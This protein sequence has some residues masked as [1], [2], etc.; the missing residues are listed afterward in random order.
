MERTLDLESGILIFIWPLPL[1]SHSMF[2]FYH[3]KG[4]HPSLP[5]WIYLYFG[6]QVKIVSKCF[7]KHKPLQNAKDFF[8]SSAEFK[9]LFINFYGYMIINPLPHL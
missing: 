1:T 6:Y 4:I 5:Q 8:D 9:S 7:K 3:K 2:C